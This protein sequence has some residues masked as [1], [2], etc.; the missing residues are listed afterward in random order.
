MCPASRRSIVA[1]LSAISMFLTLTIPV[2]AHGG[3]GGG[4]DGGGHG[5]G[6]RAGG[7]YHYAG[8]GHGSSWRG[9]THGYLPDYAGNAPSS[10][11]WPS[12]PEDLP[13][14]RLHNYLVGHRPHWHSGLF[15]HI[16]HT[17]HGPNSST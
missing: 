15:R 5:A 6:G 3:G 10:I 9:W 7:G 14:V 1:I 16:N 17:S 8:P 11:G 13:L 12:F 2:Y 4:H